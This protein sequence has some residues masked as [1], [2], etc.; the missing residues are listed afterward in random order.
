MS[1]VGLLAL[2]D[3]ITA[4]LDDVA[5]MTKVASTKTAGIVGDDLA[6]NAQTLLGID[7]KRELPIVW[8]VAKGS[9]RNKVILVP[10]ALFL[11]AFAP[12]AI[13][14]LLMLGGAY[15]CFEAAEKVVH[16]MKPTKDDA[17]HRKEVV[18]AG[19]DA[20]LALE[21]KKIRQAVNTD[22]ILSAEIVAV[23][24]AA[25]RQA[26]FAVQASVLTA[27]ALGMTA[28]V[29]G[30]VGGIVKLDDLGFHLAARKSRIARRA[31]KAIL[32]GA[33]YLMKT[34]SVVGTIAMFMVGGGII[35]HG[36][37]PAQHALHGLGTLVNLLAGT[38]AGAFIGALCLPLGHILEGPLGKLAAR[39]KALKAK[40]GKK[41]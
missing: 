15:L 1:A 34:L 21:E 25:V 19:P 30:L 6:V 31:G 28:V 38:A 23:A 11:S 4:I 2:L 20:L 40:I 12:W 16:A 17:E 9:L 24:L 14:P 35:L 29:Y 36:I 26:E 5:A 3:D 13:V 37:P 7:P 32:A 8:R 22:F 41:G 18:A 10:A 27:V 39:V 33:P